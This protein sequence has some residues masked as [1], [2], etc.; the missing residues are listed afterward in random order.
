MARRAFKST[1][2]TNTFLTV[3]PSFLSVDFLVCF[4][5]VCYTLLLIL[6]VSLKDWTLVY[7]YPQVPELEKALRTPFWR[8]HFDQKDFMIWFIFGFLQRNEFTISCIIR[9]LRMIDSFVKSM[10]FV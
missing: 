9:F 1:Q 2:K 4:I 3:R 7:Y 8:Y 10:G 5:C 6:V